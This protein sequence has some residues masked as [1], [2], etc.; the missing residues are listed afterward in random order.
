MSEYRI[1][2]SLIGSICEWRLFRLKPYNLN[3]TH[4]IVNHVYFWDPID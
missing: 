4:I 1:I 3:I 2:S